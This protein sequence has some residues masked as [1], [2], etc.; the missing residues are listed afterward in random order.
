MQTNNS[1]N[2]ETTKDR[3]TRI[4]TELT[5]WVVKIITIGSAAAKAIDFFG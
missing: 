4:L 5:S 3:A 1:L 2:H